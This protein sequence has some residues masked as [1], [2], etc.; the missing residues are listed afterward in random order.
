MM[1]IDDDLNGNL[2]EDNLE[3]VIAENG[4]TRI[5]VG[6]V[7][8]EVVVRIEAEK[9]GYFSNGSR[10]TLQPGE[11]RDVTIILT[12]EDTDEPGVRTA[13]T[14]GDLSQGSLTVS[15]TAQDDVN[16]VRTSV[17]IPQDLQ[18]LDV[19]GNELDN[20]LRIAVAH[21]DSR[22]AQALTAFPGGFDVHVE[23]IT[24]VN[25]RSIEGL[26]PSE[27][28]PPLDQQ[29]A[30]EVSPEVI[31]QSA[32]FTA[33]DIF[34]SQG[35]KADTFN[36]AID[37]SM[38]IP[39]NAENPNTGN[40]IAAGDV[41]PLWSFDTDTAEWNYEGTEPVS[42]AANNDLQVNFQ[43][44]H[45][46]YW[47]LDFFTADTCD[48]EINIQI[49]SFF[50]D[51][52]ND[53]PI[54]LTL[55]GSGN[56]T[57]YRRD[58]MLRSG[59]I[60]LRGIS[61]Q[62][63][64]RAQFQSLNSAAVFDPVMLNGQA[65]N[66]EELDLCGGANNFTVQSSLST[67]TTG[68]IFDFQYVVNV[69]ALCSNAPAEGLQPLSDVHTF[70]SSNNGDTYVSERTNSRGDVRVGGRGNSVGTLYASYNGQVLSQDVTDINTEDR[71]VDFVFDTSCVL[72]TGVTGIT[73]INGQ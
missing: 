19:D 45:L 59:N 36:G 53:V 60:L 63:G 35:R 17:T 44:D 6:N 23:N 47:N 48:A 72:A 5:P 32:G 37:V 33:I 11:E 13:T 14:Q 50:N 2:I 42:Q 70:F 28:V 52:V 10:Y 8:G 34:D 15:T 16:A 3:T 65:Y 29:L 20:Q 62:I 57:G 69:S 40:F 12:A 61:S 31:F 41:M 26:V 4:A 21:Y 68:S 27:F 55:L 66:G 1:V 43:A 30:Q 58:E 71:D 46:S 64:L 49:N 9:A 67:N 51:I 25:T 54:N 7:A 18:I 38:T 24:E 73:G 56:N 22:D 39:E